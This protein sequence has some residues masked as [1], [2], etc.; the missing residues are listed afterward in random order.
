MHD[1]SRMLK[2][3]E[4][5]EQNEAPK[6]YVTVHLSMSAEEW[7]SVAEAYYDDDPKIQ[8][9]KVSDI[10]RCTCNGGAE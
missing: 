3:E 10:Y 5:E 2:V 8:S 7:R 6:G 4:K 9:I 1:T